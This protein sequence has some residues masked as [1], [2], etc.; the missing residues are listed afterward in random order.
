MLSFRKPGTKA[1]RGFTLIE[2]LVV[3]AIIGILAAI[4]F[5]VFARV[6]ETA[7]SASCQSNLKQIGLAVM[8]YSQDH[9]DRMPISGSSVGGDTV[10][11]LERY[12]KSKF[13]TGIWRCPSHASFQENT[14]TSSYGYN[15]SY[16]LR[17]GGGPYPHSYPTGLD[18]SGVSLAFLRRPSETLLFV[19]QNVIASNPNLWCY[20]ARPTDTTTDD[21]IGRVHL[22]HLERAN[23]LFCDGHV[24]SIGAGLVDP[25]NETRY[26]DPR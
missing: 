12:T 25:A 2:I 10:G 8:Q 3:I 20:V 22:R 15:W 11:L 14:W 4:L 26:W 19:D 5:P 17:A 9:N 21:G 6:R 18:N 24:K 16:L 1:H 7:R 23:V 13:G